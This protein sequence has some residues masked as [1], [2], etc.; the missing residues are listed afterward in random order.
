MQKLILARVLAREPRL[1]LASQP[2]RGLDVGS[3]AAIRDALVEQADRGRA[4]LFSSEELDESLT[5]ATRLL[6]MHGGRI[7]AERDPRTVDQAELGR[8]L[9]GAPPAC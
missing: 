1:I 2:T 3:A 5:I 8:L 7:V 9:T 6:V 4:V